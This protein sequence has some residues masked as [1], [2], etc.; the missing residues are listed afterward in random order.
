MDG[1]RRMFWQYTMAGGMGSWW[2]HT[3]PNPE[4]LHT[5][6]VFW[7]DNNRFLLEM[8]PENSLSEGAYVLA[9]PGKSHLIFY[10]EDCNSINMDLSGMPGPKAAIAVDTKKVYKEIKLGELDA[11]KHSWQAPY[12]SD[13]A[14]AV[15]E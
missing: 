14:I 12:Q 7:V 3:Y 15:G 2:G 10:Q 9:D 5:H 13:W 4:Q 11:K 1:T 8:Q 6:L